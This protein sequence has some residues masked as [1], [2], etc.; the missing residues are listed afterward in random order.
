MPQRATHV[1]RFAARIGFFSRSRSLSNCV[2][3][4]AAKHP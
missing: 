2:I 1:K 4:L 3:D